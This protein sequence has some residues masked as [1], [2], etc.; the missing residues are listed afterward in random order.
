MLGLNIIEELLKLQ[1]KCREMKW[2]IFEWGSEDRMSCKWFFFRRRISYHRGARPDGCTTATTTMF[3]IRQVTEASVRQRVCGGYLL[4]QIVGE[5]VAGLTLPRFQCLPPEMTI[6]IPDRYENSVSWQSRV[7]SADSRLQAGRT[8]QLT[9][10]CSRKIGTQSHKLI[11]TPRG[12]EC[13]I[14]FVANLREWC[15]T[16]RL[17]FQVQNFKLKFQ[18]RIN[19]PFINLRI[20][21]WK[22][23][24]LNIYVFSNTHNRL[25]EV[26]YARDSN[27]FF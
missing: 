18:S 8:T 7:K 16:F 27:F 6:S 10:A 2:R 19:K 24:I 9:S 1:R 12:R 3:S 21:N 22:F 14:L 25:A 26:I 11:V 5:G 4:G 20:S 15:Q 23:C 17:G 13:K